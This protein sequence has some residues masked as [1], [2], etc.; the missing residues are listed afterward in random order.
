TR[1]TVLEQDWGYVLIESER[2][3]RP[4]GVRATRQLTRC[5]HHQQWNEHTAGACFQVF[6]P[7]AAVAAGKQRV[8]LVA[9]GRLREWV[10][11][12]P[13]SHS[14]KHLELELHAEFEEASLQDRRRFLPEWPE[15]VVLREHCVNVQ[16]VV[17]IDV[18][19]NR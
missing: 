2:S 16:R 1:S 12:G 11:V 13:V 18:C 3:A 6:I 8:H 4:L 9:W 19:L 15:R 10:G 7:V 14:A 17:D 5:Q